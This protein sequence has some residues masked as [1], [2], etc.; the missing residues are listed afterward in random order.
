MSLVGRLRY[1]LSILENQYRIV[2][3]AYVDDGGALHERVELTV[4]GV[5]TNLGCRF[6]CAILEMKK[7]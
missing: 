5:A 1:L 3:L 7:Q 2:S 4:E 6:G